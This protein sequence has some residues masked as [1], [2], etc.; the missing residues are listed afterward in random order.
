MKH[1]NKPSEAKTIQSGFSTC[2][3]ELI[4]ENFQGLRLYLYDL[5]PQG[6]ILKS[7]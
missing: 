3:G 4:S 1:M 6:L 2:E 7:L 5:R